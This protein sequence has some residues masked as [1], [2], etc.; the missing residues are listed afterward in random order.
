MR[1]LLLTLSLAVLASC[2]AR[3]TIGKA[4]SGSD[5]SAANPRLCNCIQSVANRTL[6]RADQRRA[7]PFF[8]DPDKAQEMRARDDAGSEAFW[9]RYKD[10]AEAA[11]R[12]CR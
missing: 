3:G 12:S 6:S 4:C 7:A 2:G 8:E 5:R 10:F 9:R 1:I 11:E